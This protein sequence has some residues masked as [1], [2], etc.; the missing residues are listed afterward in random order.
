MMNFHPRFPRAALALLV[1]TILA[2]GFTPARARNEETAQPVPLALSKAT[3]RKAADGIVMRFGSASEKG[4]DVVAADVRVEGK[5]EATG[6]GRKHAPTSDETLCRRA[7]NDGLA[8]LA[9]AAKAAGAAAVVG[10]VSDY[11]GVEAHADGQFYECHSGAHSFVAFK[12]QLAR[13]V[14]DDPAYP[15]SGF[16]SLDDVSALPVSAEGK[17]RY[18]AFLA[19]PRPRAFAI[20]EDGGSYM[21]SGRLDAPAMVLRHCAS[22]G[23]RCWLYAVDGQV[24]WSAD[25]AKRLGDAQQLPGATTD[26]DNE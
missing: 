11:K 8:K 22:E 3:A 6:S 25:V 20:F 1:A 24:V 21:S 17:E 9:A 4:A 5:G 12:G 16:A 18:Q 15:A 2:T 13:T 19:K 26:D 14:P 23:K 10:I 7:F